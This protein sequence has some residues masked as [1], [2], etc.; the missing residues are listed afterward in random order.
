VSKVPAAVRRSLQQST[1]WAVRSVAP[2][3]PDGL[4]DAV[5]EPTKRALRR[6]GVDPS[7]GRVTTKRIWPGVVEHAS[8]RV[9]GLTF[10]ALIGPGEGRTLLDL[11]AGPCQFARRARDAGWQVTAVD[12]R[13]ERLPDDIEGITFIEADV[14]EFD[15]SGFDTIAILGLLYHLPLDEQERLLARC[16][17]ARVILETQVH[18]PGFVPPDAE[19]WGRD[20]VKRDGYRGVIFPEGDNPMAS[21]GNPESFWATE[22]S[23][24]DMFD[25]CGYR[26]V[27]LVEPMHHSKYGTRRFYVLNGVS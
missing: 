25:R 22:R 19:P 26:S 23:L 3:V 13:T 18:T 15:P 17:Y 6:I 21:I 14:R 24:L 9:R 16:A 8:N 1:E 5:R 7:R 27:Q 2:H 4:A 20:I 11:G 10:A 12:A